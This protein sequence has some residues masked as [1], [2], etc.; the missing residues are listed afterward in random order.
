MLTSFKGCLVGY[1]G[2]P[3]SAGVLPV[4]SAK[5]LLEALFAMGKELKHIVKRQL[6]NLYELARSAAIKKLTA[7]WGD[8]ITK[9]EKSVGSPACSALDSRLWE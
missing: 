3:T 4:L 1:E 6:P 5:L 7:I 2:L 8:R 9:D